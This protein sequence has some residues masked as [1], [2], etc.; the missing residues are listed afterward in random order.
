MS[1]PN[2]YFENAAAMAAN[3]MN[4]M[5]RLYWHKHSN[6]NSKDQ[7]SER[8]LTNH[9]AFSLANLFTESR[10]VYSMYFEATVNGKRLDALFKLN[11]PNMFILI[12]ARHLLARDDERGYSIKRDVEKVCQI[13]HYIQNQ[14]PGY[15]FTNVIIADSWHEEDLPVWENEPSLDGF[16]K[17]SYKIR[18]QDDY[19]WQLHLAISPNGESR[20]QPKEEAEDL[21]AQAAELIVGIS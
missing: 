19:N 4:K 18:K 7:P 5:T 11:N 21:S 10:V 6:E 12:E 13:K 3:A 8:N 9:F 17:S 1:L 20:Y 16:V 2:Y 14:F 15:D